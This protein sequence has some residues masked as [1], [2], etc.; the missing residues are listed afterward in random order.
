M[1]LKDATLFSGVGGCH[2]AP[3][4]E[5]CHAAPWCWRMPHCFVVLEDVT[6]LHGVEGCNAAPWC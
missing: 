6:L 1:M 4:V 3:S 2:A 5:E